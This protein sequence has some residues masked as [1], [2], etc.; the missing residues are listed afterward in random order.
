MELSGASSSTIVAAAIAAAITAANFSGLN[1][2]GNV[3]TFRFRFRFRLGGSGFNPNRFGDVGVFLNR[4]DVGVFVNRFSDGAATSPF[5]NRFDGFDGFRGFDGFN[6]LVN[7]FGGFDG[8]DNRNLVNRLAI[9]APL[10]SH[11][12]CLIVDQEP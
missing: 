7:P 5:V 2:C 12:Q 3:P 4:F 8:F 9:Y 6:N 1:R 10:T 11:N